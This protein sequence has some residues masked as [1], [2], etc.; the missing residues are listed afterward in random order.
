[1]T[2]VQNTTAENGSVVDATGTTVVDA[3]QLAQAGHRI[4]V[5]A[6]T[7]EQLIATTKV[8]RYNSSL[9]PGDP[10][11]GYQRPP[12]RSRITRIGTYLIKKQGD[13]LY[14]NAVLL[15][16]RTPLLF[17]A[18]SRRLELPGEPTL[19]VID[20][21][22]RIAGLRYA[23]EEKGES[24]LAFLP[25][26]TVIV[27]I[28]DHTEEMNQFRIING[29]AKAVRTDLVNSILTAI[30]EEQGSDVIPEKDHWRVVVTK[31]VDALNRRDDSPWQDILLMPDEVG[32]SGS[33]KITRATS[34]ITSIRIIYDWLEQF[35]FLAGKNLDERAEYLTD[36]LVAYWRA[37][38][39]VV[40]D[41]FE[42]PADYVIQK[43][44]GLFALHYLLRD[45]LLGDIYR[46]RRAWD[47]STFEEFIVD[48]PEIAD[49]NFWHK[50]ASRAAAYGSMKGF[51]DLADLLIDSIAP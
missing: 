39:N 17:D 36:V 48:S 40:P 31:A 34:A 28:Q 35:G 27:E 42:N 16:S 41:A 32:A 51:R 33:G 47:E 9:R 13:G 38:R 50:D 7:A 24:T 21:Q 4:F 5:A 37:I 14:P 12:E 11:Q 10:N 44:P 25:I 30:A 15:G 43:T 45:S 20:G 6:L 22:H 18:I 2:T 23:I 46:G 29:T 3:V 26:P 1:M 19:R 8:D 49:A